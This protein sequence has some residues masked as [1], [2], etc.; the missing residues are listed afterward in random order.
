MSASFIVPVLFALA[1]LAAIWYFVY[2]KKQNKP[3]VVPSIV[4]PPPPAGVWSFQY[5]ANMVPGQTP[6]SFD[7]PSTDGVHYCVKRP[8]ALAQGKTV[9]MKFTITGTGT[10]LPVQGSK[11]YVTLYMQRAGDNLSGAGPY[12]FYRAWAGGDSALLGPGS[13]TIAV[14]LTPDK[15]GSVMGHSFSTSPSSFTD[16]LAN[17]Q[18]IGFTFG[19]PGAGATGHGVYVK[20]GT[21]H[22]TLD[23]YTVS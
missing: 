8:P 2:Y 12:E 14:P 5:S 1:G 19:D 17:A 3:A 18:S 23:S 11:P 21:A 10:L 4:E 6:E 15:W 7:F 20:N 13:F 9:T 22:F 16:L